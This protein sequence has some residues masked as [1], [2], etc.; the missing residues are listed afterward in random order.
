MAS[1]TTIPIA[2]VSDDN[3]MRF[4][5]LSVAKRYMNDTMSEISHLRRGYYIFTDKGNY[6]DILLLS[7]DALLTEGSLES[8]QK[9]AY[10]LKDCGL[11]VS[12]QVLPNG[13]LIQQEIPYG[14]PDYWCDITP[15]KYRKN[16]INVPLFHNGELL[17]LNFSQEIE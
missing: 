7:K 5:E 14:H 10:S 11:V 17:E 16:I 8:L 3:E 6:S 2:T 4:K 13:K 12:Q 1:S 9:H 15:S